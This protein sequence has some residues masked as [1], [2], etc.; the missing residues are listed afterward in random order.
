MMKYIRV[1]WIHVIPSEP[2][3]IYSEVDSNRWERRKVEIYADGRMGFAEDGRSVGG[4][5]L[6]TEP[7][8]A[9]DEIA[10]DSQFVPTEISEDDF[11][12]IWAAALSMRGV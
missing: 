6:S 8:P 1:N 4:S 5:M 3:C 9:E 12:S 10:A 2:T 11:E 7:L